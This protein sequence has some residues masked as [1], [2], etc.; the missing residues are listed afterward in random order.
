MKP[1]VL[2]IMDGWGISNETDNNAIEMANTPIFDE[3][4]ETY[5]NGVMH[6]SGEFVGLPND[7]MGNSEV[8]HMNLG[9]GRVVLQDLPRINTAIEKGLLAKNQ[10]LKQL[11]KTSQSVNGKCH[12]IGLLSD[13]GVHSHQ[14]HLEALANFLVAAG[15]EVYVHAIS[16]G[17]DTSPKT[18]KTCIDNFIKNTNGRAPIVSLIGRFYA[19]DRDNRWDRVQKAFN[20]IVNAE[21]KYSDNLIEEIDNQYKRGITD[22]F[23]E[24]VINNEYQGIS[25]GDTLL[26]GNFRADRAREILSA[27]VDPNFNS[28]NRLRIPNLAF[29]AGLVAYSEL[30]NQ[31]LNVLFPT[32]N[33]DET[34]G[35]IVAKQ[36]LKQL[37]IAETE[38]YPHVTFF[39]NGGR[40]EKF[41]GE[42][43]ILIPSPK[44]ATYDLEPEM[45]A[46][47]L[48]K[49]L[50]HAIQENKFDFIVVNYANPDMVGHTGDLKAAIK[51]VETVDE[52]IGYLVQELKKIDGLMFLTSDH[53]N[54]EMMYDTNTQTTHT[55]H[56]TNLVPTVLVNASSEVFE[57]KNGKLADV[58][59]TL[60]ELL[61]LPIPQSMNGQ[62]MLVT[63]RN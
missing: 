1:L 58:A 7:Q 60:L 15:T 49:K 32:V 3:L 37:R 47:I 22:E 52:C 11:I 33:L 38:K 62:S 18:A 31:H 40:E 25:D 4:M 44:V 36:G 12:I 46:R 9:A 30:L 54:C 5:P 28:F 2:C 24:P 10:P 56:T 29:K 41:L 55:S 34:I 16:D 57:L 63:S 8:G 20:A 59:P 6:A 17:R 43:R 35:E 39:L 19:M 26:F 48:T 53:G 61:G 23:L 27:I 21:G 51:A 45:S 13:G 50:V 14:K 42:E